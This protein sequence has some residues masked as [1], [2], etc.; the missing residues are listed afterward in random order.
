[1]RK[2]I[3]N[4]LE[5][6]H[7]LLIFSMILPIIYMLGVQREA[8]MLIRLYAAGYLI[9]VP[10]LIMKQAAR[11][12]SN[13][14]VYLA[15]GVAAFVT[16]GVIAWGVGR[17][18]LSGETRI[19]YLLYMLIGT[20]LIMMEEYSVRMDRI[21]RKRAREE[22]DI[23]W[24]QKE[25]TLDKPH[26]YV[27]IWYVVM[28]LTALN[29]DCPEV[30]NL[31]I[32]GFFLYLITAV[33]YQ[34]IEKTEEY[35]SIND[36]VCHVRN[37][38]YKRI[39]GI[40]K[41]FVLSFLLVALLAAIP[42]VLT[43]PLRQYKDMREW[44]QEWSA[45][46]AELLEQEAAKGNTEDP[47]AGLALSYGEPGETPFLFK[48]LLYA[49]SIAFLAAVLRAALRWIREELRDFKAG[50]DEDGDIVETLIP[51]TES[52]MAFK[53]DRRH[54]TTEE[55]I[56]REYRRFIRKNRKDRPNLYETPREIEMLAG[57]ADTVEGQ[58]MHE[59]Y[60]LARYGHN[61]CR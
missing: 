61:E 59:R 46:Y 20:V 8:G 44:I 42:T 18:V 41:Y 17:V 37:I 23:S 4:V 53:H 12:S 30:C 32:L 24:R 21:R 19:G 3:K 14:P 49:I 55:Q 15:V 39:F 58:D 2:G 6:L 36:T 56:R 57:V 45:D 11:R 33:I 31:S 34:F 22:M 1:M 13:L 43:V 10:L 47:M 9:V 27:C 35:L 51:E 40:G 54:K 38:P 60:E 29:S 52:F 48:L 50:V 16:A 25:Y 5:G 7:V 28:Y 26:L